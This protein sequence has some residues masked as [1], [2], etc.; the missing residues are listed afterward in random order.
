MKKIILVFILLAM[1]SFVSATEIN[2]V[3][4][5]N[6][7]VSEFNQPAEFK[8]MISDA[9]P[10]VYNLYTLADVNLK[11][12]ESFNVSNDKILNVEIYKMESLKTKG[13]YTF[14]YYLN[15]ADNNATLDKMTIK[16]INLID[17]VTINSD[18]NIPDSNNIKFYVQGTK[19]LILK[20][21]TATFSSIFFDETT[22]TF[23]LIEDKKILFNIPV[24][25]EKMKLISAGSYVVNAKF[26]TDSEDINVKGKI[27]LNE[28]QGI[29][30]SEDYSGFLIYTDTF[31]K[32]NTGNVNEEVSIVI[33]RNIFT[34]FIT[35]FSSNPDLT[36]RNGFEITYIW[37]KTISAGEIFTIKA[38]TNYV[39]PFFI[40][41]I[42]GII[43]WFIWKYFQTKISISK[44]ARHIKT[45]GGQ[46][47]LKIQ[48]SIKAKTNLENVSIIDKV[49]LM[50]KI[51][52]KFKD[53]PPTKFD[54]KNRKIQWDIGSLIAG[55][56]RKFSY[57]VYSKVGIIGKLSLPK[58]IIV[59]EKD[60]K[61]CRIKGNKI[62]FLNEQ[63]SK[64]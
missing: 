32:I 33:K 26:K 18:S 15:N 41:I 64:E 1:C 45:K 30:S 39:F 35:S 6:V 27:N 10:G 17:A 57:I 13:F 23:D 22:K 11:P 56:K 50:V 48:L 52:N 31:L 34:R 36:G 20:N 60:N 40:I 59:Y 5:N 43:I 25:P 53:T 61:T 42:A 54:I 24:N 38:Y 9:T 14:N 12:V 58:T 16:I 46:F 62:F 4:I 8:I 7:I 55:E 47:A 19:G 29:E 44:T 2:N 28:K 49:P 21:V 63:I 51:Y 3:A 37:N